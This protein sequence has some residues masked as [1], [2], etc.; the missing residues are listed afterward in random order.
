MVSQQQNLSSF[1]EVASYLLSDMKIILLIL[2]MILVCFFFFYLGFLS[3]TFTNHRAA[4]E[5]GG[6]FFNSSLP[7]PPA[8]QA[9]RHWPGDYCRELTSAR[10]QQPDSNRE[11]LVSER[12]SLTTKLRALS[13]RSQP[14]FMSLFH[15]V[16]TIQNFAFHRLS[17][18]KDQQLYICLRPLV[19]R[20]DALS[21]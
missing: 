4:G 21:N 10:S 7:L 17:F 9:I 5:G 20:S 14:L 11:P 1:Y 3:R 18:G 2:T 6:H 8:S 13:G 19:S 15:D 12:K 16:T